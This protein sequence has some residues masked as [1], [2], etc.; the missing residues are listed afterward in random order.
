MVVS[1]SLRGITAQGRTKAAATIHDDF[2]LGVGI[3]LF[4]VPL[5][6][7]LAQ[8]HGIGGVAGL[9]FMVFPHIEEHKPGIDGKASPRLGHAEFLDVFLGFGDDFEKGR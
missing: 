1:H 9:P 2:R 5:Q 3:L 4:Q 7:S 6:N 8:M